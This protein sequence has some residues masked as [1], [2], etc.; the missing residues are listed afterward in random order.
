M[1]VCLLQVVRPELKEGMHYVRVR[2]EDSVTGAIGEAVTQ[3]RS[4]VQG[5]GF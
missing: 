1:P 4:N 2:I 3:F 5:F